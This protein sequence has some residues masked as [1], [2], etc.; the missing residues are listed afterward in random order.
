MLTFLNL[1]RLNYPALARR[2]NRSYV[3]LESDEIAMVKAILSDNMASL[4]V[5]DDEASAIISEG[6]YPET[7]LITNFGVMPKLGWWYNEYG[8]PF[9]LESKLARSYKWGL[10]ADSYVLK[11]L[12]DWNGNTR[13]SMLHNMRATAFRV[14]FNVPAMQV[15]P[16]RGGKAFI[17][18]VVTRLP[19]VTLYDNRKACEE[20]YGGFKG[21]APAKPWVKG[22]RDHIKDAAIQAERDRVAR[23]A[24]AELDAVRGNA[25]HRVI[26]DDIPPIDIEIADL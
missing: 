17:G 26:I 24:F 12:Y 11:T 4:M 5:H 19:A 3:L 23:Q 8:M 15:L 9:T 22:V 10:N 7:R 21:E 18:G 14:M 2:L 16:L 1:N 6:H 20:F 13:T 25:V